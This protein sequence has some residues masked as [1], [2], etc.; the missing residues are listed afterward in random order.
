MTS[1]SPLEW[2]HE[3]GQRDRDS[4]PFYALLGPPPGTD[5]Q[6]ELATSPLSHH[7][8]RAANS[9]HE[10]R[11]AN[12][13]RRFPGTCRERRLVR[14]RSHRGCSRLVYHQP[15]QHEQDLNFFLFA[16]AQLPAREEPAHPCAVSSSRRNHS[17]AFANAAGLKLAIPVISLP[18]TRLL[19]S[20]VPS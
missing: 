10:H 1:S 11:A 19:M 13:D 16:S 20:Y 12:I 6:R 8:H 5:L 2:A 14:V 18:V 7:E 9:H 17:R 15:W 3:L 4:D